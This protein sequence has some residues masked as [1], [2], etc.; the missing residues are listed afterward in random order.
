MIMYNLNLK[1]LNA[2]ILLNLLQQFHYEILQINMN[3]VYL[4]FMI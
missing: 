2:L 1:I 4:Q 3:H